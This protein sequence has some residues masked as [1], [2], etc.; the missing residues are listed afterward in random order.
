M[1]LDIYKRHEPAHKLSY[2]IVPAGREIPQ[3]AISTEWVAHARSVELDEHA[4]ELAEFGIEKPEH[5]LDE[6]G[7]AIT[8][9]DH[10]LEERG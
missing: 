8:S 9:L 7:Y 4:A 5:Q 3:E 1:Q 10:Q 2:L 6:K